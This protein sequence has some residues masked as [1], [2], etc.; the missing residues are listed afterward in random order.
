MLERLDQLRD[1][2][3]KMRHL[4]IVSEL[5][6]GDNYKTVKKG[7]HLKIE[8]IGELLNQAESRN[9]GPETLAQFEK[10]M[11]LVLPLGI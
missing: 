5:L 6:D 2:D 1:L 9:D 8:H 10:L 3:G 11:A 4:R 7:Q